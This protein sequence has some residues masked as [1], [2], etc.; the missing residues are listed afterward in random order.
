[1]TLTH[2]DAAALLATARDKR[3][4]KP[5]ANNTRLV[6]H[7]GGAFAVVLHD[8]R[9]VIIHPDGSYTLDSGGWMTRTTLSRMRQFS[10]ALL[11][12]SCRSG[13]W[14]RPV[15]L[16]QPWR[17]YRQSWRSAEGAPEHVQV[18]EPGRRA[19][20]RRFRE[21]EAQ[22]WAPFYDGVRIGADGMPLG[23]DDYNSERA[24]EDA[25]RPLRMGAT[26]RMREHEARRQELLRAIRAVRL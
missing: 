17:L 23:D 22:H 14:A 25:R 21:W 10:P 20:L 6:S 18:G 9:I 12:G 16:A 24:Q 15:V 11:S 13:W 5:L 8:T 1:M 2:A 19:Y 4:G 3:R 7:H 26:A